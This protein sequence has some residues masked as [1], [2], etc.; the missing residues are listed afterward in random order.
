MESLI[1]I[2]TG[3]P[4]LMEPCEKHTENGKCA[5][6]GS[7][8]MVVILIMIINVITTMK[9]IIFLSELEN[10]AIFVSYSRLVIYVT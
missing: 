1:D 7:F 5:L 4:F 2:S 6:L 3:P 8:S 9:K 10:R